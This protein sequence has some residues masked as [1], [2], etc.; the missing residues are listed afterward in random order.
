MEVGLHISNVFL[1]YQLDIVILNL[2]FLFLFF[3]VDIAIFK[4]SCKLAV[5]LVT[6]EIAY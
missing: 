3:E 5:Q 2:L 4:L 1:K 6:N